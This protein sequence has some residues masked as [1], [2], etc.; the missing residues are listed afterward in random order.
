MLLRVYKSN[1][2]TVAFVTCVTLAF[3]RLRCLELAFAATERSAL[4]LAEEWPFR[5]VGHSSLTSLESAHR[6]QHRQFL[7]VTIGIT[8]AVSSHIH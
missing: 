4:R 3:A 1:S 5:Y 2:A 6:I 7:P 8:G